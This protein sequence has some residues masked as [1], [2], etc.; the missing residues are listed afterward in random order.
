M[1]CSGV[2]FVAYEWREV[3][4]GFEDEV[5]NHPYLEVEPVQITPE[6]PKAAPESPKPKAA[7]RR[8]RQTKPKETKEE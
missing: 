1:A 8:R 7:P 4:A 5:E 2:E 6:P 3:P